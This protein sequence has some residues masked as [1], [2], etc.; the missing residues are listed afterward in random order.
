MVRREAHYRGRV[1]GVGFRYT[2]RTIAGRYRVTGYVENLT[3][4]RVHL[5]AEGEPAEVDDFL[6]AV[7]DEMSGNIRD[8]TVDALAA[9][10]EYLS[11]EIRPTRT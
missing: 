8:A 10:G 4:G 9:S 7:A 1:Q 6:A 11:F 2:A 5:V 3:D